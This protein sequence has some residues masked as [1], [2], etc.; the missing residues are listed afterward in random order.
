LLADE[1]LADRVDE[2]QERLDEAQEAVRFI[3]QFG[4]HLAKLE[5]VVS[6]LQNDPEQYEQLKEDYAYSQQVQREA[7]QQAFAL[8]EVVQRRAH[9]SYSD[10][11]EMLSGNNDLNEKLRQRLEQAERERSRTREALRSHAAQLSQYNQVLASLKSSFDTKKNCS[12]ICK[13]SCRKLVCVPTVARRSARVF[14]ATSCMPSCPATVP[15]A[16]NWKKR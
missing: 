3:Q 11:A 6:V 8:I 10:S 13:K 1:T 16:I 15:A 12:T 4:N 7:R 2:I 14:V 5:P 9:F